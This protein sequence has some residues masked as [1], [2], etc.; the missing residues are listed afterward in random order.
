MKQGKIIANLHLGKRIPSNG[1]GAN[2]N[3]SK[4]NSSDFTQIFFL[5]YFLE[6]SLQNMYSVYLLGVLILYY[7]NLLG[8]N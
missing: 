2:L 8:I 3:F 1:S 6:Y 5:P 7:L 4:P